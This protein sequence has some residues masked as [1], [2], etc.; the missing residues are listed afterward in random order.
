MTKILRIGGD[1]SK[2]TFHYG[3]DDKGRIL[4]DKICRFSSFCPD[5]IQMNKSL[6]EGVPK[7]DLLEQYDEVCTHPV[8][9]EMRKKSCIMYQKFLEISSPYEKNRKLEYYQKVL[10]EELWKKD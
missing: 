7:K 6:E 2:R 3:R 8:G 5:I 4:E 9:Y 10:G 1:R